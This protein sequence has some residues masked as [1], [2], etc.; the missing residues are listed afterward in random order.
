MERDSAGREKKRGARRRERI[1]VFMRRLASAILAEEEGV[2]PRP[3]PEMILPDEAQ[4]ILD[5]LIS[6]DLAAPYCRLVSAA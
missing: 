6:A 2:L 3:A 4:E 5:I 1:G